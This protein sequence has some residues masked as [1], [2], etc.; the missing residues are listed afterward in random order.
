MD[1]ILRSLAD[2]INIHIEPLAL[3]ACCV[4]EQN[5]LFPK[6]VLSTQKY[7]WTLTSSQRMDAID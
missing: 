7:T 3:S 2:L 4:P 1:G 6:V 5:T